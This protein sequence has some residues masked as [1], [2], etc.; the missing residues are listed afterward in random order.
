MILPEMVQT[1]LVINSSDCKLF[2]DRNL[3]YLRADTSKI[4]SCT[5]SYANNI[6]KYYNIYDYCPLYF[7]SVP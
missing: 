6:L 2:V 7:L 4:R 1:F 3:E 5:F